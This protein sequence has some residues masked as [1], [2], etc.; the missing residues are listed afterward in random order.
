MRA[1]V[2]SGGGGLGAFQVGA[3]KYAREAKGYDWDLIAGVS[4]GALNGAMMAM[5][6]Y[7]RLYELWSSEM[8]NT[9]VYGLLGRLV[10]T[11]LLRLRSLYS[12]R[13]LRRLVERELGQGTFQVP[14]L[15]G[16]V[17]LIT[18]KYE[19][20]D[21][22]LEQHQTIL[23]AVLASAAMPVIAPPERVGP[24]PWMID[25]G[26]RNTSPVGDVLKENPP[27][28]EVVIV[29]CL[30][31]DPAPLAGPPRTFVGIGIRSYDVMA[32]EIFREDVKEFLLING[33][34]QEAQQSGAVLHHPD[35]G[36]V[37]REVANKIIQPLV[38]LGD[39][40]E[41]SKEQALPLLDEGRRRAE[42]ALR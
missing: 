29:N 31:R 36:R 39:G 40:L 10:P 38:P 34:V 41:F 20:F 16:A 9:L 6:R 33:L 13:A 30:P 19:L 26:V 4:V 42:E 18:G 21:S 5:G 12:R 3:E 32:N 17:S 8:S 14:L 7:Q 28:D 27:P 15:V 24:S 35:D 23:N 22:R 25:G 2:L 1:L 11:G 37:L